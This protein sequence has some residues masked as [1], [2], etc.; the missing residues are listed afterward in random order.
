MF[1]LG[2]VHRQINRAG[3]ARWAAG[4]LG[5]DPYGMREPLA[6]AGLRYID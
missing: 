6:R 1:E 2:R 3:Q 5:L 4:E